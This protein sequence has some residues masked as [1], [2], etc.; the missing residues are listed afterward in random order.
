MRG[1][2]T[3]RICGSYRIGEAE[4]N[5]KQY[6][7]NELGG[8]MAGRTDG[9]VHPV[10]KWTLLNEFIRMFAWLRHRKARRTIEPHY[11]SSLSSLSFCRNL[12]RMVICME[13]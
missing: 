9:E 1:S 4:W 11:Y 6:E 12:L 10:N 2:E 13:P 3:S 7:L 5:S 8:I